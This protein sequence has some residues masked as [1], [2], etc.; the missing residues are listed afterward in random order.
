MHPS[1]PVLL[2]WHHPRRAAWGFPLMLP[3]PAWITETGLPW[4]GRKQNT[5]LPKWGHLA[6]RPQ[7]ACYGEPEGTAEAPVGW[8]R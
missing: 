2:S 3:E 8:Q 6:L 1:N 5:A 7:V 4:L